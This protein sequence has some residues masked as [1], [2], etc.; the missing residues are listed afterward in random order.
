MTIDG[1]EV[2][3]SKLASKDEI[4]AILKNGSGSDSSLSEVRA[5]YFERFGNDLIWTYPISDG[6]YNGYTI[7]P[8]KEGFL[9]LPFD[10]VEGSE[11][12][13]F[14]VDNAALLGADDFEHL[15]SIWQ[16]YSKSIVAA[17]T[18]MQR[19]LRGE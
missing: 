8:V 12:E 18:D 2:D 9:A 16:S 7:V 5:D 14:E 11:Y 1:V 4:I 10:Y 19:T 17:M 6:T 15:I 13:I 3:A